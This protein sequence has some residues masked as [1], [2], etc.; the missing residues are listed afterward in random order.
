MADSAKARSVKKALP[1]KGKSAAKPKAPAAGARKTAARA[2]KPKAV[3]STAPEAESAAKP[4]KARGLRRVKALKGFEEILKKQAELDAATKKAKAG[5]K[6]EYER[7]QKQADAI[8]EQYKAL[9]KESIETASPKAARGGRKARAAGAAGPFSKAEVESYIEQK[10]NGISIDK[11]KI[12]GRRIKSIK[13]IEDAYN[14]AA[15]KGSDSILAI[16]G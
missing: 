1:A 12:A 14:R 9:F 15:D 4:R 6:K 16:L 3:A 7:A 2:A 11:M 10:E 5:L 13:R 8:K